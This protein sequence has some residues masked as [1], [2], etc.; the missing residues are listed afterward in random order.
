MEGERDEGRREMRREMRE[1]ALE[2]D[3]HQDCIGSEGVGWVVEEEGEEVGWGKFIVK[4]ERSREILRERCC[5]VF[6]G[7][8]V[9]IGNSLVFDLTKTKMVNYMIK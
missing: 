6:V 5:E 7:R 1:R 3:S 4:W 2:I 8:D 9:L